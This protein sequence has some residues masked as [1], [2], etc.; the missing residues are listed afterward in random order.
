MRFHE[1]GEWGVAVAFTVLLG[2]A[3]VSDIRARTIPN[4]TVVA[5]VGLF[6]PWA[7]LHWGAWAAW[8]LLAGAIALA[9]G[10]ALYSFG[11][12]GAGDAKLFA[13]VALFAGLGHLLTLGVWTALAGGLIALVSIASRPNRALVMVSLRGKGDFGRG[14]PYGVAI[15]AAGAVMVWAG[16]LSLPTSF[17]VGP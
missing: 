4:W 16:L 12:V 1:M 6:L 10:V 8:T 9:I 7:L 15:A 17:S 13:A 2:W 11:V 5:I 3:A 14:V